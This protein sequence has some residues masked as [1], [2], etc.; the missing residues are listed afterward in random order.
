MYVVVLIVRVIVS[1]D[2][3]D[4]RLLSIVECQGC[5]VVMLLSGQDPCTSHERV[6]GPC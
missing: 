4:V 3:V 1:I 6:E 2:C 5:D